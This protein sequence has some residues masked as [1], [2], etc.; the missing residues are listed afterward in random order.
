MCLPVLACLPINSYTAKPEPKTPVKPATIEQRALSW[1]ITVCT[2]FGYERKTA[3]F[4]V[5][6]EHRYDQFLMENR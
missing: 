1:S 2:K 3:E 5:C 4:G 6:A